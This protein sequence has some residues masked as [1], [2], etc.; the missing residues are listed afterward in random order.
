MRDKFERIYTADEMRVAII[1]RGVW[2]AY[3]YGPDGLLKTS[4]TGTNVVT[5]NGKDFVASFLVSAAAAASTFTCKYVAV[6]T[7]TTPETVSDTTLGAEVTR[8]TATVS[9]NGTGVYQLVA[10]F[11]TGS[12][13]GAITEYGIFS[14]SSNGT[15]LARDTESVVNV[16]SSDTLTVT[17]Q[18][19]LSQGKEEWELANKTITLKSTTFLNFLGPSPST[20]WNSFKWTTSGVGPGN[21]TWGLKSAACMG[22]TPII[23]AFFKNAL[24]HSSMSIG[25]SCPASSIFRNL[26]KTWNNQATFIYKNSEKYLTIGRYFYVYPDKVTNIENESIPIYSTPVGG[27]SG[28]VAQA[29]SGAITWSTST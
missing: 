23:K 20:K 24:T 11:S 9:H 18:I 25:I 1:P 28:W 29:S 7:G 5:T 3:V 13:T 2:S 6:G 17:A 4:V 19:T 14:A 15:M 16:G 22:T 10:S 12:A 8:T 26:E 21:G 27:A